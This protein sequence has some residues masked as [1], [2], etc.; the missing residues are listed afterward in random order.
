MRCSR[1]I[2]LP[3]IPME[4]FATDVVIDA[5]E[6]APDECVATFSGIHVDIATAIFFESRSEMKCRKESVAQLCA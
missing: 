6:S 2:E 4:V 5:D 3:K 1:E